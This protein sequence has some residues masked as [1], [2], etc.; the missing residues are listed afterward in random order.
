MNLGQAVAVCL[1]EVSRARALQE[2]REK[3]TTATAAELERIGLAL[4]QA[5]KASG[6]FEEAPGSSRLQDLRRFVRRLQ[7]DHSD[8]EL[9]LGMLRQITWKLRKE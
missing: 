9:L 8:A 6:Y 1:Y 5:L 3:P 2:K 4:A 7:V